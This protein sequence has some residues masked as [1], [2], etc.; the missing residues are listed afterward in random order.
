MDAFQMP[1]NVLHYDNLQ[2]VILKIIGTT[3]PLKMQSIRI[4]KIIHI[5][6]KEML[7]QKGEKKLSQYE[8]SGENYLFWAF[9]EFQKPVF[10][11]RR[12]DEIKLC[13]HFIFGQ[14]TTCN[15]AI[16]FDAREIDFLHWAKIAYAR[17]W[18]DKDDIREMQIAYY[19]DDFGKLL[20]SRS[21]LER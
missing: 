20:Q 8:L 17:K 2:S 7:Q 16:F 9:I 19:Q 5:E 14:L 12:F 10:R 21:I 11:K 1:H 4:A 6:H 18:F 13:Q 15:G 3:Y